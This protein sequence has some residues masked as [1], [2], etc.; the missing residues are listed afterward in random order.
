MFLYLINELFLGSLE[1]EVD[2]DMVFVCKW[3]VRYV[4]VM[5][6]FDGYFVV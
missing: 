3:M 2:M 4:D 6:C 1:G 5:L